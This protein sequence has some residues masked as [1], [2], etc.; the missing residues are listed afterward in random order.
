ML[1]TSTILGATSLK[2]LE[3]NLA[4]ITFEIPTEL[5]KKLDE[6]SGIESVHPYMFFDEVL[7]DRVRG[8]VKVNKW[9]SEC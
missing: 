5:R 8:G 4:S 9:K 6:A 7:Q 3:S 2:Q 1:I